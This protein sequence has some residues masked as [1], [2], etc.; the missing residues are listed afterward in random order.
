M[1]VEAVE[2]LFLLILLVLVALVEVVMVV[3]TQQT[4]PHLAMPTQEAV[5]AVHQV[6]ITEAQAVAVSSSS[7]I[8][9]YS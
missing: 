3:Q 6:H 7:A 2:A 4:Q 9:T 8:Q 1:A 5:V